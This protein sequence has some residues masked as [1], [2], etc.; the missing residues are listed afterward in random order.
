MA[1]E[2]LAIDDPAAALAGWAAFPGY[3][4]A[5]D[6][7]GPA[8]IGRPPEAPRLEGLPPADLLGA[9]WKYMT[10]AE[11]RAVVRWFRARTTEF[12]WEQDGRV[13]EIGGHPAAAPVQPA[14]DDVFRFEF[15]GV[16]GNAIDLGCD[17]G[18][19][20]TCYA[21]AQPGRPSVGLCPYCYSAVR[22]DACGS[23]CRAQCV[24][25]EEPRGP[26]LW[27]DPDSRRPAPMCSLCLRYCGRPGQPRSYVLPLEFRNYSSGR[28]VVDYDGGGGS[29]AAVAGGGAGDGASDGAVDGP[30]WPPAGFA[31]AHGRLVKVSAVCGDCAGTSWGRAAVAAQGLRPSGVRLDEAAI[32]TKLGI[33]PL[34]EWC[35]IAKRP[36]FSA[37]PGDDPYDGKYVCEMFGNF[38]DEAEPGDG[39]TAGQGLFLAVRAAP[40]RRHYGSPGQAQARTLVLAIRYEDE[41]RIY[42]YARDFADIAADLVGGRLLECAR[43][44]YKTPRESIVPGLY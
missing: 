28:E 34:A 11:S 36:W 4:S 39:L 22:T 44:C 10:V 15:G 6:N 24:R 40:A 29:D 35:F 25:C 33:G 38:P 18:L 43:E 32:T 1:A 26:L 42:P 27:V 8:E 12:G 7:V 31:H 41:G 16:Q 9:A 20:D 2:H 14:E 3:A 37:E 19:C 17:I 23:S 21:F 13:R 30:G 5:D